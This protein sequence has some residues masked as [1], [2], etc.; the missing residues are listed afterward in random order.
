MLCKLVGGEARETLFALL[1]GED[2][3]S[4]LD[5]GA[6][7]LTAV[8]LLRTFADPSVDKTYRRKALDEAERYIKPPKVILNKEEY[9]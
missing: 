2:Y 7:I 8:A 3:R 6:K 4:E 5:M 1:E 9:V